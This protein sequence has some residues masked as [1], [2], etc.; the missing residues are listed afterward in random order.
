MAKVEHRKARKDYPGAGISKGDMY[1]FAQI[2]T[3]P[4]SSR[5]IR[6]K[7]PIKRSQLTTSEYL[8]TLYG[9]CEQTDDTNDL[10]DFRT[11]AEDL[12]EL[13]Q[14]QRDKFDNMP[15]GLQQGD[16]GQMLEERAEACESA[17]DEIETLIDSWNEADARQE[18]LDEADE[19]DG[20]LDEGQIEDRVKEK[21]EALLEEIKGNMPDG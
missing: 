16:T 8:S 15:E 4:R 5:T 12:R 21:L 6:Q 11:I 14:E 2:K 20:D 1:Y 9:L 19:A 7:D 10:E 13:G 3:G 18:V 17:A